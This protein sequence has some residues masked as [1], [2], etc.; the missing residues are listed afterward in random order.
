MLPALEDLL[1]RLHVVA[2]PMRSGS[3][4][5]TLREVAL[6]DGPAGWGEFGAFLE[7]EPPRKPR[8]GWRPGSNPPPRNASRAADQHPD[9]RHGARV[10]AERV[11]EVLARFPGTRTAKVKVAEPGRR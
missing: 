5:I 7:Y 2:L 3:R 1:D 8:T 9:Q 11:P 6:I 4:G 10:S